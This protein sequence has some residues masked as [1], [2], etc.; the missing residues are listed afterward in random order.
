[1]FERPEVTATPVAELTPHQIRSK[2]L[3]EAIAK[4]K[5][6]GI[7]ELWHIEAG[8][9][10]ILIKCPNDKLFA[11]ATGK[12]AEDKRKAPEALKELAMAIVVHPDADTF[13]AL[14]EK[15]PG[16]AM[17]VANDGLAIAS[18]EEAAFAKK[19]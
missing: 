7:E 4:A 11:R 3:A 19:V 18:E 15:R 8:E 12:S 16:I 17:K 13:R 9:H 1:M 5:E 2:R 6:K 14:C 10:D